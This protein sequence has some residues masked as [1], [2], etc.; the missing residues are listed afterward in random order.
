MMDGVEV[1]KYA[2]TVVG[3]FVKARASADNADECV[4]VAPLSNG[5]RAVRDSKNPVGPALHFTA[6][7]WSAFLDGA[8][9][10]E[11]DL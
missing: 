1:G 4:E 7:E 8:K 3:P 6:G 2:A 5:G 11:F 9:G 10:G